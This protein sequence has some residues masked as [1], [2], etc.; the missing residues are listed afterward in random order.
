MV[1]F[2]KPQGGMALWLNFHQQYPL[3]K[4][5]PI[6][7]RKGVII[8]GSVYDKSSGAGYNHFRFGFASLE[9]HELFQTVEAMAGL[10]TGRI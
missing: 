7:A 5:L 2:T 6:L 8:T 9:A 3:E 10:C 1:S 4:M